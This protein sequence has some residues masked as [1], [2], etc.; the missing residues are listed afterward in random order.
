MCEKGSRSP[1]CT[2]ASTTSIGADRPATQVVHERWPEYT[3]GP[4]EWYA[5]MRSDTPA[6]PDKGS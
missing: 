6:P 2:L 1:G 5:A 3:F 4:L